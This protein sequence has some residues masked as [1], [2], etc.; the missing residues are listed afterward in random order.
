MGNTCTTFWG[1]CTNE[2]KTIDDENMGFDNNN[3]D[4]Q[5]MPDNNN[6]NGGEV[7]KKAKKSTHRVGSA[8]RIN[9]NIKETS[10]KNVEK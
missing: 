7:I 2:V 5:R 4:I 1:N 6:E 8:P 9:W 10:G 3:N